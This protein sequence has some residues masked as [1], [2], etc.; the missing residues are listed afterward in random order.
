MNNLYRR[1]FSYTLLVQL[2]SV[3]VD[4]VQQL[5][6]YFQNHSRL[7]IYYTIHRRRLHRSSGK[8]A[9]VPAEQPVQIISPLYY[10][11]PDL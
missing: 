7:V 11:A 4:A 8:I 2:H 9:P 10:F 1:A 6:V 3:T 5:T